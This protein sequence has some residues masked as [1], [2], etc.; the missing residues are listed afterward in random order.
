MVGLTLELG[1]LLL[2]Q[3]FHHLETTRDESEQTTSNAATRG[4]AQGRT[5]PSRSRAPAASDRKGAQ[6]FKKSC[7]VPFRSTR[8]PP[9]PDRSKVS[10]RSTLQP[11]RQVQ[12][13]QDEGKKKKLE[14]NDGL[15][16]ATARGSLAAAP[17]AAQQA[18]SSVS[19]QRALWPKPSR[20]GLATLPLHPPASARGEH[21]HVQDPPL[22]K[23]LR[24]L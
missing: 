19:H 13:S 24:E 14:R 22:P 23:N 8:T 4:S 3:L 17:P 20:K 15:A 7:P 6:K 1:N 2:G 21:Q 10:T 11:R 5:S 18:S 9:P 12:S 16:G